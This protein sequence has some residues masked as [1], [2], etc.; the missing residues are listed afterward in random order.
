MKWVAF[1]IALS[2]FVAGCTAPPPPAQGGPESPAPLS[3]ERLRDL[4]ALVEAYPDFLAGH[5][6][7]TLVWKDGTK[8]PIS[9]GRA[10]KSAEETLEDPDIEDIFHWAYPLGASDDPPPTDFDPGRARPA[11]LFGKMYGDCEAGEVDK[12]LAQVAWVGAKN[13]A[14]TSVNRADKALAAVARDLEALGPKYAAYLDPIAGTYSCRAI[15]GTE[16]RSMHAFAAAIDI[17]TANSDYWRWSGG[18][19]EM[20]PYQNRIPLEI[21]RVFEKHGFIWGGRWAHFDT[22]HFEYR[23]EM[24]LAAERARGEAH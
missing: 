15:A 8:T 11:A 5:D 2:A 19:K 13:I 21:V 10:D 12:K 1:A 22:M 14:F 6:G 20:R 23:P 17:N 18:A 7:A 16:R 4:D 3:A 9:D 24:V